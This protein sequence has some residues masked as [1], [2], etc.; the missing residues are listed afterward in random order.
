MRIA[1]ILLFVSWTIAGQS[2]ARKWNE[3]VLNGVRNDFARPTVHARNLFHSSV[4][5]Y[6]AWA[7]FDERSRPFFLGRQVGDYTF[8]FKGFSTGVPVV[9]AREEAISYAAYRL[10]KHRFRNSP[11]RETIFRS[12]DSLMEVLGYDQNYTQVDYSN[13]KPAALGNYIAREIIRFGLQDG[14]NE[15]NDYEN[16]F[17]EPL[18]GPLNMDNA[19]N[20]DMLYPNHWQP[21]RVENYVDQSG[22]VIPGGQPPFLGPEWGQ[23]TPFALSKE[24]V[25]IY[26]TNNFDYYVYH[27]PGPPPLMGQGM[28]LDD[29]YKWGFALVAVWAAHL[30]ADLPEQID[31]S[32]G[33]LGNLD[34]DSYPSNFDDYR[35][36]YNFIEGGDPS[37]GRAINP[38]TGQPYQPQ[39]VPLGDYARVLAEFW[40]DGPDSETPPGH[41]FT[42]LNYVQDQPEFEP[43][44]KG[45][46]QLMDQLEWD[47]KAYFTLGG[48]MHDAAVSAWGI[49]GYYD[50]VRPVSAIRYMAD[51]G[52]STDPALPSYHPE[53]I[54]LVPGYIEVVEE[55]DPLSGGV[56]ENIGK[57][58]LYSW[59]GP[60]FIVDP[61]NDE[62]GVGWILAEEWWPYQRP[63][64]VTPPFAGYVSGHSTFSRAAAEV[65][66]I[67]TG[68]EYFPGGMGVFP[69][70]ADE[71]LEFEKGPSVSFELQWATYRD[72]SDQTSLSRIWGGIHPPCDDLPGRLIG[73]EI[74]KDAVVYA[75]T[76]FNGKEYE[77]GAIFPNP[78]G[79]ELTIAY[80]SKDRLQLN[81]YDIQGRQV[82]TAPALFDQGSLMQLNV[83]FLSPGMY[84]VSLEDPNTGL[85]SRGRYMFKRLI[86]R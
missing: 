18:N 54:P 59:R 77:E 56:G 5:M 11:G 58:K 29:N 62:A 48:A 25:S 33:S 86:K 83:A 68:D 63:S 66:T 49:K 22:N 50:Y 60:D 76:F 34:I 31:I 70:E 42:I 57:I 9:E 26:P 52:Q 15:Q 82:F 14:A 39:I 27:D 8:E 7:V 16:R 17:Y 51:R 67:I 12:V 40:A 85:Y 28:G 69:V 20:P 1:F 37:M 36:F 80:R 75:E 64:F 10:I 23:V 21:L 41:W 81:I 13:G 53:G 79:D 38:R 44:F 47:V 72:A 65:L 19:G 43:R 2:V 35:D 74:G 55:G 24:D 71:F 4:A 73:E 30:D 3:E 32:P 84:F 78:A 45:S 6:D 61:L 46:G